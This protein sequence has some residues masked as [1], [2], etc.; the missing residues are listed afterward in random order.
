MDSNEDG[1]GG[2]GFWI[3]QTASTQEDVWRRAAPFLDT[4]RRARV[5]QIVGSF[6]PWVQA[7]TAQ[8]R[9]LREAEEAERKAHLWC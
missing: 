2:A 7:S 9:W 8:R 4:A 1:T 5:R 3:A 6:D